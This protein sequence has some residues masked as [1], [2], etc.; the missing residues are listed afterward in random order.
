[1]F[2]TLRMTRKK[3]PEKIIQSRLQ[4][5]SRILRKLIIQIRTENKLNKVNLVNPITNQLNQSQTV[6]KI[7]KK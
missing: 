5:N 2:A 7:N 6:M 4:R 1:M 3:E